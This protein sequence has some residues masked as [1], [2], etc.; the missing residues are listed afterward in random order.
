MEISYFSTK[1]DIEEGKLL[2]TMKANLTGGQI[3]AFSDIE[4]L[5]DD[6]E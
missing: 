3:T 2:S 4:K 6:L 5:K 1:H